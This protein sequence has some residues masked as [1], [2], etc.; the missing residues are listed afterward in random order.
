MT[1]DKNIMDV[2][3]IT[4]EGDYNKPASDYAQY[5][6]MPEEKFN[7]RSFCSYH[8]KL[9]FLNFTENDIEISI[10]RQSQFADGYRSLFLIAW[11]HF[12][13]STY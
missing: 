13:K 7:D 2:R 9:A 10:M 12:A 6:W 1:K 5:K 8:D 11:D 3:I 4:K